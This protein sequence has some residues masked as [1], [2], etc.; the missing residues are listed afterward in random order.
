MLSYDQRSVIS[1]RFG[2]IQAARPLRDD[3]NQSSSIGT[4]CSAPP[5][6]NSVVS[7]RAAALDYLPAKSFSD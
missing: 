2:V 3:S 4:W 5:D 6:A 7:S 1:I